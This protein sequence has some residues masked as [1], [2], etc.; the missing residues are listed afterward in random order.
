MPS[1]LYDPDKG[2]ARANWRNSMLGVLDCVFWAYLALY[3][4]WTNRR[5]EGSIGFEPMLEGV[6]AVCAI[7]GIAAF[8]L[9][10]LGLWVW[11]LIALAIYTL[12]PLLV[13]AYCYLRTR[14]GRG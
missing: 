9:A 6:A 3:A 2:S 5:D 7:V 8:V 12:S 11:C 10:C 1:R 4:W 13:L 14:P